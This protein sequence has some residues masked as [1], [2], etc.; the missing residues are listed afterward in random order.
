MI[1]Q[2]A[3]LF[4]ELNAIENVLFPIRIFGE[5]VK[6]YK[7]KA[8]QLLEQLHISHCAKQIP[9]YLSGGERQR[10]AI[11]RALI[12]QPKLIIADEPTGNLDEENATN[13]IQMLCS[14]CKENDSSLLLVTHNLAF[15]KLMDVNYKV[16]NRHLS[17]C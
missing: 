3:N 10:V 12:A 11:A 15:T 9:E 5:R 6:D 4:P 16:H 17:P 14:L 7:S 8:N 2:S 13:V 1:F